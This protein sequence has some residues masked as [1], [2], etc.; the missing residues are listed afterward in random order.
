MTVTTTTSTTSPDT[1]ARGVA[2]LGWLPPSTLVFAALLGAGAAVGA[3]AAP[4]VSEALARDLPGWVT[5][6]A[7]EAIEDP[8]PARNYLQVALFGWA[9]LVL[10][11]YAVIEST[12]L[13]TAVEPPARALAVRIA[14]LTAGVL[15]LAL[16]TSAG[17]LVTRPAAGLLGEITARD[18]LLL[19]FALVPLALACAGL[20]ML[21][22]VAVRRWRVALIA[23]GVE[24][25]AVYAANVGAD[26]DSSLDAM[27]Y[28]SPFHYA[29]AKILAVHGVVPWHVALLLV[30]FVLQIGA[31]LAIDARG[32]RARGA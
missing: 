4:W 27:R 16:A 7:G 32:R 10:A 2:A 3:L 24:T 23:A 18:L 19:P 26:L 25:V 6:F 21:I 11:A 14:S 30:A 13:A 28:G 20:G 12:R 8:R 31:A 29:D 1:A 9:P 22:G 17:L 15:L 5:A